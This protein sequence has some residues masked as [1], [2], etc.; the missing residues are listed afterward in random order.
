[1]IRVPVLLR[2]LLIACSVAFCL[3]AVRDDCL[4]FDEVAHL[5]A[6]MSYLETRDFRLNLEQPPLVKLLAALP[7]SWIGA[8]LPLDTPYWSEGEQFQFGQVTLFAIGNDTTALT[9]AARAVLMIFL[10]A[11]ALC[12][13]SWAARLFGPWAALAPVALFCFSPTL[14]GH[15][16]RVNMDYPAAVTMLLA[17]YFFVECL[18]SP[19][20][21]SVI[22]FGLTTGLALCTKF[23]CLLLLPA[24]ALVLVVFALEQRL[25]ARA[26]TPLLARFAAAAAICVAVIFA[27]YLFRG[28]AFGLYID[29]IKSVYANQS[30][31]YEFYLYGE[32]SDRPFWY[33]YFAAFLIKTTLPAVILGIAGIVAVSFSARIARHERA[34]LVLLVVIPL[35]AGVLDTRNLGVRRI[36]SIYPILFLCSGAL[37]AGTWRSVIVAALTA[38][39]CAIALY[40]APYLLSYYDPIFTRGEPLIT[41]LDDSNI[42]W[43]QDLIR[44]ARWEDEHKIDSVKLAYF[45]TADPTYYGVRATPATLEELQYGLTQEGYLALSAYGALRYSLTNRAV[46]NAID[47]LANTPETIIGTS[48]YVYRFSVVR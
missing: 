6:G 32:L 5:P 39:H 7:M 27:C 30:E 8:Q 2:C 21:R 17:S 40:S 43:G 35:I 36:F 29:G 1:M 9:R 44:L 10:V 11:G 45:G 16:P 4:T 46:P 37:V 3:W 42:D 18:R 38:V 12:L 28:D 31:G 23:G 34:L 48:I 13:G 14:L 20:W 47:W 41:A 25:G 33:Y 24:F 19:R 22:A 15:A 26:L